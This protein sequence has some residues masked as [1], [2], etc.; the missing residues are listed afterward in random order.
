M[1]FR[2]FRYSPEKDGLEIKIQVPHIFLNAY[3][4]VDVISYAF[5]N[6]EYQ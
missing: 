3:V 5:Y 4:Y 2:R 1:G 6:A